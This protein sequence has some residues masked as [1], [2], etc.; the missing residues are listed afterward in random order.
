ML[1]WAAALA[2][3]DGSSGFTRALL[4]PESYLSDV[5][6]VGD[7]PLGY[8]RHFTE[9]AGEHSIATRGH[10]P[11]PVL[12]L[13]LVQKAGLTDHLALGLV[14]TAIGALA[15]PLTLMAF[16]D[17]C[18]ETAARRAAP[19]L[20]LATSA[21]WLAVSMDAVV[22]TIVAA[23]I[24]AGGRASRA[25][26]WR[27]GGWAV[28]AGMLLGTAALFSYAAAWLGLSIVCLYFARRRAALNIASGIGAL[29]PVIT[30]W[31]VGFSWMDGLTSA[32][33]DFTTRVEPARP[34]LAWAAISIVALLLAAGPGLVASLRKSRTTPGWPFLVGAGVAVVFSIVAGLARGGVEHAWLPYFAW[35]CVAA[36][37]PEERGGPIPPT[38]LLLTAVGALTAIV[39]EAVL[40]TPW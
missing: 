28:L 11:A 29:I 5:T 19:L 34:A 22:A 4:D 35:L 39:V 25:R 10:P 36:T 26:A 7:D 23:M 18:G 31:L 1:S 38:P 37:A 17:A 2:I 32:H 21:V 8:L 30:V 15:V 12:L 27:A 33:L 9:R 24:V 3:V 6:A 40:A 16:K 20:I 13:W 14:F